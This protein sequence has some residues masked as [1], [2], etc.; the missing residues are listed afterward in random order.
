MLWQEL[1]QV[2]QPSERFEISLDQITDDVTFTRR[3]ESFVTYR[4]NRLYDRLKQMLTQARQRELGQRMQSSTSIQSQQQIKRYLRQV[5]RFLELLLVCVHITSGQLGRGSKVTTMRHRNSV[6]Q[7][8]NIFVTD[9]HI[10]TVVRYYKSQ[11]Q[12]NKPKIV[13]RFLPPQVRQIIAVYLAY[14][15][16]F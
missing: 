8:C 10:I 6:L 14:L 5:D 13:P 9:R 16:L 15:Q 2:A 3:S 12:Q 11:S 7:D 1:L 4:D